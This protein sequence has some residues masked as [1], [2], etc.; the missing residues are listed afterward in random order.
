MASALTVPT[1]LTE[2]IENPVGES[3]APVQHF[4]MWQWLRT[5]MSRANSGPPSLRTVVAPTGDPYREDPRLRLVEREV[6]PCDLD[7]LLAALDTASLAWRRRRC[8]FDVLGGARSRVMSVR[9]RDTDQIVPTGMTCASND[10]PEL[11]IDLALA[12]VPLFGPMLVDVPFAG[13][14][15]V[16]GT[17]DRRAL[18]EEAAQRIQQIGRRVAARAPISFPILVDLARRMR[19]PR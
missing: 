8:G 3:K 13:T 6:E 14:M 12:L 10:A 1:S 19:Q 5:L 15:F 9:V 18:G 7:Q 4:R 2:P 17:R 16:D 11:L